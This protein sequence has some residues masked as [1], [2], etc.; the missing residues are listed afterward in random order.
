VIVWGDPRAVEGVKVTEQVPF[1]RSQVLDEKTP[2]PS[3]D[4]VTVPDGLAPDT[5]AVTVVGSNDE[6]VPG[7]S[8]TVVVVAGNVCPMTREAPI[9]AE[10]GMSP[11]IDAWGFTVIPVAATHPYPEK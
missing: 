5:V 2:D 9:R 4:Q 3:L 8:C 7:F 6:I 10:T 11:H 1:A